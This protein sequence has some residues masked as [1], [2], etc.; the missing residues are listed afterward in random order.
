MSVVS[1]R[2]KLSDVARLAGVS[3]ATVSRVLNS[4]T[5]VAQDLVERVLKAKAELNYRH[6]SLARGLRTKENNMVGVVIPD[7]TNPFFTD[8]VRG[9]EDV[10]QEASYL[11]V[12]CNTDETHTKE[13]DYLNMLVDQ[14][15]A[16]VLI[17]PSQSGSSSAGEVLQGVPTVLVDR[18]MLGLDVDSVTLDNL[19][20]ARELTAD[21]ISRAKRVATITGPLV[22]TTANERLTG[23]RRALDAAGRPFEP[24]YFIESDYSEQGGYQAAL[25]LLALPYPPDGILAGNNAMARGMMRALR[26]R[27]VDVNQMALAS[28]GTLDWFAD[29]GRHVAV[30]NIPSYEMGRSAAA[31]LLERIDGLESAQRHVRVNPGAIVN[32]GE[33]P[34]I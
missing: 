5:R 15:V 2:A 27:E 12:L 6:N 10:M 1:E 7:I 22:T 3:P 30:L 31:M 29:P 17:A 24:D 34:T 26:E 11:L 14:N 25:R 16:G 21:L 28:F 23:Y 4:N 18:L 13:M 19:S 33:A 20:G 32:S 8:L 9:I